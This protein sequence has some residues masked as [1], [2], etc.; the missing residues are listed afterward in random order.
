M[1]GVEKDRFNNVFS[2][3]IRSS[4]CMNINRKN[5]DKILSQS[6]PN[7]IVQKIN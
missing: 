2:T 3:T 1:F 6:G 4:K 5:Q 7:L